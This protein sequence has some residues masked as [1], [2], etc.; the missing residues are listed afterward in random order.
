MPI[1]GPDADYGLL[2]PSWA[3]TPV[4][5]AT[6]DRAVLSAILD[7]EVALVEAYTALALAPET[8]PN[9][10]RSAI[11]GTRFDPADL[12]TRAAG[13]GNPVIP[14]VGDLRKAVTAIDSGAGAWVHRGATSQ[15][16]LDTAL[17]L[18]ASRAKTGILHDVDAAIDALATLADRHRATAMVSRTLT[19]HGVPTT[20]GV[21]TAGW[22]HGLVGARRALAGAHLPVQWGGAGGTLASFEVVAGTGAGM[23]IARRMALSLGLAAPEVPWQTH[24]APITTLGDDLA[25]LSDALGTIAGNVLLLSRPEVAELAEP[26]APGRGVSSA[27]PQKHNPVLSVLIA[28]AARRSPSLAAELHRSAITVDER[29]PG[30]WHA[31][32]QAFRELIRLV[33]GASRLTAE[34]TSGLIVDAAAMRARLDEAG[35]LVISERLMLEFGPVIG[36]ARLQELVSAGGDDLPAALR[37]EPAMAQVT[38]P[39]LERALNPANYLGAADQI[40]DA[41]LREAAEGRQK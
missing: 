9:A 24:R 25:T 18:V 7:V 39:Q 26:S 30:A 12:A 33:G 29:P 31:E 21:K 23:D 35:P 40:I 13:G 27:M 34:L 15:D 11:A 32:W 17:M 3:G 16:I 37:A 41:V 22:L 19:Q 20:F 38:D 5:R 6:G 4:A 2:A 1:E 14:L 8:A 10:L 28:S 36:R